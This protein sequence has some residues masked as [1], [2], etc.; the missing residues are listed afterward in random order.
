MYK[1]TS[2][3]MQRG[4]RD[5][6]RKK[7]ILRHPRARATEDEL[8]EFST[9]ETPQDDLLDQLRPVVKRLRGANNLRPGQLAKLL[10]AEGWT[11]AQGRRWDERKVVLLLRLL[12]EQ[13]ARRRT[14]RATAPKPVTA[15]GRAPLSPEEVA[16][17]L[18]VLG[19][20]KG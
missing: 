13:A 2:K 20:V 3:S 5:I 17:R 19:G 11:T 6:P 15:N 12:A 8:R 14:V 18:S 10:N 1:T 16:R 4:G 7:P 9:G